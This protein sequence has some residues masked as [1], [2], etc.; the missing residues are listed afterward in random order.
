MSILV[1]ISV[2]WESLGTPASPPH[3]AP[4]FQGTKS[5]CSALS[6]ITDQ[7]PKQSF[8]PRSSHPRSQ[9]VDI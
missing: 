3:K 2:D 1:V 7:P 9:L 4:I 5:S 8:S 6:S